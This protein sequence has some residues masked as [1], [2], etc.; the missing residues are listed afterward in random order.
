MRT[1]N[2]QF[3][4]GNSGNPA[5]GSA[6]TRNK[7]KLKQEYDK[8]AREA[9]GPD[10]LRIQLDLLKKASELG[11]V[12]ATIE[13]INRMVGLLK[14]GTQE[15]TIEHKLLVQEWELKDIYKQKVD[16]I[17]KMI[18]ESMSNELFGKEL[19]RKALLVKQLVDC[20]FNFSKYL[21]V[22]NK[23]NQQDFDESQRLTIEDKTNEMDD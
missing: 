6:L 7:F 10:D 12:K 22:S 23:P 17:E 14:A 19:M 20:D 4:K 9:L 18:R 15:G 2:G 5:G 11:D 13:L 16:F 21:E 8:V 1:N 3:K